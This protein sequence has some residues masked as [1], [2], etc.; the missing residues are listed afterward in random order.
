MEAVP[1]VH[2]FDELPELLVEVVEAPGLGAGSQGLLGSDAHHLT[3]VEH[4]VF[5][6]HEAAKVE[7]RLIS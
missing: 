7:E 5:A 2:P 6:A 1:L 4:G 3:L